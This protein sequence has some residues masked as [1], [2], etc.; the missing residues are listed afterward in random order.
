MLAEHPHSKRDDHLAREIMTTPSA[1][2]G[3]TKSDAI[4]EWISLVLSLEVDPLS[5]SVF[6]GWL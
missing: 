5:G 6:G 2:R 1:L 3:P 4:D